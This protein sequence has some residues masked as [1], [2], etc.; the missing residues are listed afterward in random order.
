M[1]FMRKSIT[2]IL[3]VLTLSL[4]FVGL[5]GLQAHALTTSTN[6]CYN[7][8]TTKVP[9]TVKIGSITVGNYTD[10]A[11]TKEGLG[12][13]APGSNVTISWSNVS[14]AIN[15][16]NHYEVY[17]GCSDA[18]DPAN[19]ISTYNFPIG[20][21]PAGVQSINWTVPNQKYCKI[22]VYAKSSN[23]PYMMNAI[24]VSNTRFINTVAGKT[25][26]SF[27][28][29]ASP[30]YLGR[31]DTQVY[32]SATNANG[33]GSCSGTGYFTQTNANTA[34][35]VTCQGDTNHNSCSNTVTVQKDTTI[36]KTPC[37]V[38]A[39]ASPSYLGRNDTQVY[40]SATNANGTGS[41]SG[42]GY[43][44]QTSSSAN[45]SINC[46]GDVNHTACAS[47]VVTVQKDTSVD[48][49][50]PTVTITA[51]PST[52][53]NGQASTLNWYSNNANYC[54]ASG[55]WSGSKNTSGSETVYP[56]NT[57][58]YTIVCYGSN[59][60]QATS[61]ATI[62]VNGTVA[63]VPVVTLN[64]TSPITAGSAT[65]L[66]WYTSNNPT[67]C[68][69][70]STNN[71]W[72]GSKNVSSGNE[73]ITLYNS[74]TYTFTI[75][76]AN[77]SGDS[78]DSA[79]V[80]V[81]N[82]QQNVTVDLTASPTSVSAGQ[83]STL[84]WYSNN[85]NYCMA[86][87]AWS[88]SK[89]TSGSET[90]YPTNNNNNYSITCYGNN[91]QANDSVNV[92]VNAQLPTV[93][94]TANPSSITSGQNSTLTWYVSNANYCTASGDWSGNK[95]TYNGSETVSP[96]KTTNYYYLVCTNNYGSN[97]ATAIVTVGGNYYYNSNVTFSKTGRNLS[98]GDRVY[99]DNISTAGGEIIEFVITV[100][101]NDYT[102]AN[103]VVVTDSLPAYLVYQPGTTK[104]N[105]VSVADGLTG[106]GL[107]LG[108]LSQ[109]TT[110]TI[111]FQALAQ[112][113]NYGTTVTNTAQFRADNAS[114]LSDGAN[115]AYNKGTVLGAET[116]DT[117]PTQAA[118]ISL[119]IA[120]VSTG[121]VAY[122]YSKN[123]KFQTL[124][125]GAKAKAINS[126]IAHWQL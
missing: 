22:W 12:Y 26:C 99:S 44:T 118:L 89:N 101:I 46:S 27:T 126:K 52:I 60:L 116:V 28:A 80:V 45:Y 109:G 16:I 125:E 59:G 84:N 67:V 95:N 42:T 110:K 68:T 74:G 66:S 81:N 21:T 104:V 47:N 35:T 58:T 1:L 90:V 53:T 117:G 49:P 50:A 75:T 78:S 96:T 120:L 10:N 122:A 55:A 98:N 19:S 124:F 103:N 113:A 32:I 102:G 111:T 87:G 11:N 65:N 36:E 72:T 70:T 63:Q 20:N 112:K 92:Y 86:S 39:A 41:C 5:F 14:G 88:G 34:Y 15:Q 37:T 57:S 77:N 24:G 2:K 38:T 8:T 54:M 85:A 51:N 13:I 4:A 62:I 6:D 121:L 76:C 25:G 108:N 56:T 119:T 48:T 115:V 97:S 40:I 23:S 114:A 43:F 3:L 83:A 30:S 69:A 106:S 61:Q 31:N 94:L 79:T 91:N 82:Y 17:S 18:D 7:G 93:T 71:L 33:T 123:S 29:T 73:S 107:Y 100:G 105:G 9:C 64:A